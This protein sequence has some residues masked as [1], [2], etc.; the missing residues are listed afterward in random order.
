MLHGKESGGLNV[1]GQPSLLCCLLLSLGLHGLFFLIPGVPVRSGD[2]WS[3]AG[4]GGGSVLVVQLRQSSPRTTQMDAGML[5]D[6]PIPE[7]EPAPAMLAQ[8]K[9]NPVAMPIPASELSLHPVLLNGEVLE[10]GAVVFPPEMSAKVVVDVLLSK[11]GR[12]ERVWQKGELNAFALWLGEQ[13]MTQ[14]RF[15][16]AE[17]EGKRVPTILRMEF[18]LAPATSVAPK[19]GGKVTQ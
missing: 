2:A 12:V 4:Q 15:R 7:L 3:A 5:S 13:L 17:S 16:P 6:M 14:V 18:N 11:E 1:A 10:S 9:E 19:E 8:A